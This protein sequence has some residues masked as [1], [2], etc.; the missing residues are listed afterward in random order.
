MLPQIKKILYAT[1]LSENARHAYLYAASMAQQYGAQIT[2]LHVVEKLTADTFLQIQGYVGE[3]QWKKLQCEKQADF[4]SAIKGR[5]GS[6][7]DEISDGLDA[8]TFQVEKILVKEGVA[9]DE[10]LYQADLNDADAIVMGTRGLGM[11]QDA[12]MGGTARRV[13]RRSKIPV[14]VVRLPED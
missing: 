13:L 12:L 7:C 2:I 3:E 8:C 14:M 10:I 1:D 6:F 4:L 11:F 5:L 9:A